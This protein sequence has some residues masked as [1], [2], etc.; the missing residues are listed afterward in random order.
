MNHRL[1]APKIRLLLPA[2]AI[3]SAIGLIHSLPPIRLDLT[4]NDLYTLSRGTR[5]ILAQLEEPITLEFYFSNRATKDMPI[6]RTYA[7]RVRELL[8]EY[9]RL[10]KGRVTLQTIDPEPFS[11]AEDQA[12]ARGL[13]GV[14]LVPGTPEVY[15]G[16]A[17]VTS[18]DE[19]AV[20]PFFNQEREA[21]LEYD[22]S[23]LLVQVSRDHAPRLAV[24]AEP[25]LLVRGGINPFK[26]EP[27]DPWVAMEKIAQFY[28]VTWLPEDFQAIPKNSDLLVLIHPKAL[29]EPALYAVD[30]FVVG[31]GNALL[32]VDPY[33]ELD[34]PPAFVQPGRKKS[35]DLNRLFRA[36]GFE[37]IP[38][39]FVGDDH[40]ATSVRIAEG[41]PASRHLGVLTLDSTAFED[42]V[43]AANL[44]K[45]MLSSAGAFRPLPETSIRFTPLIHSSEQSMLMPT[46]ALDYLFDPAILYDAFKPSG[47][48][49]ILAAQVEGRLSSAFPEGAPNPD[50]AVQIGGNADL[51]AHSA[52]R[53][54]AASTPHLNQADD[55]SQVLVVG[56]SDFLANRLWTRVQT[57]P[58]GNR[59]TTPFA[60]NAAFLINAIDHLTGHPDLISIRGRGR[61][62]RPFE[63]VE[64]LRREA[65]K[66]LQAK[67]E[68]LQ[69]KLETTERKLARLESRKNAGATGRSG[70]TG[71]L[72]PQQ[73]ETLN[74]F[75]QQRLQIRQELRRLQHRLNQEI[76]ALGTRLKLINILLVPL[77]LTL[78]VLVLHVGRKFRRAYSQPTG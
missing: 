38:A 27:Q 68:T 13:R 58:D 24:Y 40:Y 9:E 57:G 12:M 31:G 73:Q 4:E 69:Q 25:D 70:E 28:D 45:L 22:I 53:R 72:T 47:Q 48:S 30:Q 64:R 11:E 36:W 7:Q 44:D 19:T 43:I 21:Y 46:V 15:F 35:S 77:L 10:G 32:F 75:R 1:T 14:R 63:R 20:I 6:L 2:L 74:A 23:E 78:A 56:D 61:Y 59:I 34:G 8:Q 51:D 3:L 76:E 29:S 54:G 39:K 5:H 49:F 17:A 33:A 18:E 65:E 67:L 66:Q 71:G 42:N 62:E 41:R 55:P 16:V 52:P 50:P 26:H 37:Q 60:D